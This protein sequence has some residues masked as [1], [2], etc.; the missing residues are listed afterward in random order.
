MI[1]GNHDTPRSSETGSI[2]RLFEELGLDVAPTRRAGSTI[3]GSG[4][5]VLAVP[6]AALRAAERP[7]LHPDGRREYQVLLLHGEIEGVY[8]AEISGASRAAS[9]SRRSSSHA[10]G[11]ELRGA[12]AL[13]RAAPGR[14]RGWYAGALEY[15]SSN[16]WGELRDEER[17]AGPGKAWLLVDLATRRGDADSGR[18][19]APGHRPRR[20]STATASMPAQLSRD[21][22]ERVAEIT[23]G[24]D[25]SDRAAG[26]RS[27]CRATSRAAIDHAA[28]RV[29]QG[30]GAALPSRPAPP[31]RLGRAGARLRAAVGR[32]LPEVVRDYLGGRALPGRARSRGFVRA[33]WSCSR[34]SCARTRPDAD[35]SAPPRQLPAAR[36]HRARRSRRA[37]P[38]SSARTAPGRRRCSRP[39]PGRCTARRAARGTG[40]GI[41]RRG[42]PPRARGRGRGRVHARR[43]PL[44]RRAHPGRRGALPGRRGR[45]DRQQLGRGHRAAHRLIGMTREEFFNTYFT[46]QKELAVMAA[47]TPMERAKF[48]SRVLG[49][50]R[51]DRGAAPALGRPQLAPRTALRHRV[52]AGRRGDPGRR[53]SGGAR[54]IRRGRGG[55]PTAGEGLMAA[56]AEHARVRPLWQAMQQLH[57]QVRGRSRATCASRSSRSPTAAT[58]S[59]DSIAELAEAL[60]IRQRLD[61]AG[62]GGG[63]GRGPAGGAR[64]GSDA[65]PARVAHRREALGQAGE[66]SAGIAAIDERLG[67]LPTPEA[68]EGDPRHARGAARRPGRVGLAGGGAAYALGAGAAGRRDQGG[69][70]HRPGT[71]PQDAAAGVAEGRARR[72]MPHVQPASRRE[73]HRSAWGI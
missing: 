32:P 29:G 26:G 16:P 11:V 15:S 8:P 31:A 30:R 7:A 42:A 62:A 17:M 70:A 14:A 24:I 63:P 6:H 41:R 27:T 25:R 44:P 21:I 28:V 71:R 52:A 58:R 64:S 5:S 55:R 12:R 69:A 46:G 37:S 19:G 47:M 68:V 60:T 59:P 40:E 43:A 33:A 61:H 49:Y 3:R 9:S 4:S 2:L 13:S 54:A 23:G 67:A 66:A 39:S 56:E 50:E 57:D 10:A 18:H 51:L 45:P 34:R 36:G 1:A 65:W 48:L 35:P 53:G 20:R 73:L 38:A 22:A 72:R